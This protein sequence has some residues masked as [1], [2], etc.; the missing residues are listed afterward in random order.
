MNLEVIADTLETSVTWDKV[1]NC[2]ERTSSD[3]KDELKRLG[4]NGTIMYR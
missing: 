3:Y 4:V 1:E 2:I